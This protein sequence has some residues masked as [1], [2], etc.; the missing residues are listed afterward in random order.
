MFLTPHHGS[1]WSDEART[2]ARAGCRSEDHETYR[3][4]R[5]GAARRERESEAVAA[6]AALTPS[7]LVP[8]IDTATN[9]SVGVASDRA[10]PTDARGRRGQPVAAGR[11][12]VPDSLVRR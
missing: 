2:G 11:W 6:A 7:V 9:E 1:A 5:S 12:G 4:R 3:L 10:A 8:R